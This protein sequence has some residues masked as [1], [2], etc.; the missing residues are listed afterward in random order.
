VGN[1]VKQKLLLNK[2]PL[3]FICVFFLIPVFN[4]ICFPAVFSFV[5]FILNLLI[6][7]VVYGVVFGVFIYGGKQKLRAY[8]WLIISLILSSLLLTAHLVWY[9]GFN[10]DMSL[11]MSIVLFGIRFCVASVIFWLARCNA[12]N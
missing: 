11:A 1:V 10:D 7:P 6:I 5:N 12:P 2:Q 8:L 3:A 9:L 4:V